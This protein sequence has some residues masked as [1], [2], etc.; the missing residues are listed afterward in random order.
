MLVK[1]IKFT[2]PFTDE[3]VTEQHHFHLS[4]ADLV[5]MQ[6][7]EHG[8]KYTDKAGETHEGLSAKIKKI[9]ETED[10]K[11]IMAELDDVIKRSYGIKE[12]DRFVRSPEIAENFVSSEAYSE[13]FFELCT[14]AEKAAEFM[15]GIVPGNL[16]AVMEQVK[17]EAAKLET[18]EP[19]T[20]AAP[21]SESW[22][23]KRKPVIDAATPE[24]PVEVSQVD[25]ANLTASELQKGLTDGR[26]KITQ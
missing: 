23:V 16:D 10:G 13:L 15:S 14:N 25:I 21:G 12:G 9:Q 5:K 1:K 2:N 7:E 18:A 4:K 20:E 3:E 19:R 24:S 8:L 26:L 17:A 11:A 22:Q 6:L